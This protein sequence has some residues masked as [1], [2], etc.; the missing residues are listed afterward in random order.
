MNKHSRI[1][2]TPVESFNHE[3]DRLIRG[4][5]V[6]RD[7]FSP[8]DQRALKLAQYLVTTDFS[9]NSAIQQ[10]LR[11]RLAE[12]S[13]RYPV[14]NN[15]LKRFILFRDGRTLAWTGIA[16]LLLFAW[17]FGLIAPQ[18]ASATPAYTTV[19]ASAILP[20]K[21]TGPLTVAVSHNHDLFP[22]PVPTPVAMSASAVH[23][24]TQ[25]VRTPLR[26]NLRLGNQFPI[27]TTTNSK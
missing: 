24:A 21:S 4:G 9:A 13:T 5:E 15:G 14:L 27:V 25:P 20:E 11:R 19:A 12:C 16:V 26:V 6:S 10:P 23:S 8:E 7:D 1:R 22:K 3:L 18:H 2:Q 17:T